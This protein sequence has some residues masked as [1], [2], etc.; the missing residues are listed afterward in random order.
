MKFLG[1]KASNNKGFSLVETLI[2]VAIIA[3]VG[4][5][6]FFAFA[7]YRTA[8][9]TS[10]TTIYPRAADNYS[11]TPSLLGCKTVVSSTQTRIYLRMTK[12]VNSTIVRQVAYIK[13]SDGTGSGYILG[14]TTWSGST[15]NVLATTAYKKINYILT[16]FDTAPYFTRHGFGAAVTGSTTF[17]EYTPQLLTNC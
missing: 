13:Y 2:I 3:V 7:R 9:A 11:P 16:F 8:H 1:D 6:G 4:G 10:W 15:V 17:T 14:T 5:A 12:S